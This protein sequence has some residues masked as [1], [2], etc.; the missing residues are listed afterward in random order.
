MITESI[1]LNEHA[2]LKTY[3]WDE[4]DELEVVARP[5][6]LVFPGGGYMMCS[7][8]EAEPIALAYMAEG[9]N[10]FVLRYTTTTDF[11]PAFE[12][13]QQALRL[14]RN[15]AQRWHVIS[16]RIAVCGF[17]AG[18]HLAC[19][20]GVMAQEKPNAMVLG[21]P[22]VVGEDWKRISDK[23][24]DLVSQV[25]SDAVPAYIFSCFDDMVVPP[26]NSIAL[27]D[28]LNKHHVPFECHIFHRGGHGFSLAK[29]LTSSGN[30]EYVNNAASTWFSMSVTWLKAVI[31]DLD[32]RTKATLPPD[33]PPAIHHSIVELLNQ[34]DTHSILLRYS[35]EFAQE[36]M[37][38]MPENAPLSALVFHVGLSEPQIVA[39]ANDLQQAISK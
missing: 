34:E 21:Y 33:L 30:Q 32:I 39:L 22:A 15:N 16:D 37:Q 2:Q 25:K 24:P 26:H 3:L 36:Y 20:M 14:I 17:S 8:R 10:T 4:S 7:D 38:K 1:K 13:A 9:Y 29:T 31:G 28:A 23:V 11:D 35:G 19:A 12:E 6:V 5:A 18:G 27:M